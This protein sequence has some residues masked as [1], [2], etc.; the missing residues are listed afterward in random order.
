MASVTDGRAATAPPRPAGTDRR[1]PVEPPGAVDDRPPHPHDAAP[2]ASSSPPSSS[3]RRPP[4]ASG[5]SRSPTTTRSPAIARSS[6]PG[7]VPAGSTLIPGVEINAIVTRDLGLWE[8]ELHILGF[9]MDPA[10]EAFEAAL[11][12]QRGARR[13]R[14]ERTV[15]RLRELGLPIDDHVAATSSGPTT[16]RSAGRPSPGR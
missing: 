2:T 14:F 8:G 10:D 1:R 3:R 5:S 6:R 4:P 7:D 13:E 11:A 12:A 16:T 9:G 15:A